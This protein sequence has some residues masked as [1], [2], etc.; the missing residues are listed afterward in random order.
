VLAQVGASYR[1]G[2]TVAGHGSVTRALPV[3]LR[4]PVKQKNGPV[5]ESL[6]FSFFQMGSSSIEIVPSILEVA[7]E[8]QNRERKIHMW[9]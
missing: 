7:I 5:S 3:T 9:L 4:Q 2:E 8:S 6:F 1:A